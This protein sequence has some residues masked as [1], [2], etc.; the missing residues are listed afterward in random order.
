MFVRTKRPNAIA[1]PKQSSAGAGPAANEAAGADGS[2]PKQTTR[3]RRMAE[4]F[5]RKG[6]PHSAEALLWAAAICEND[7]SESTVVGVVRSIIWAAT[8]DQKR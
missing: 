5:R 6:R 4:V 2:V 8:R 1:A 3:L 7:P